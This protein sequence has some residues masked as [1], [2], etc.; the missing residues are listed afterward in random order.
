MTAYRD[1]PTPFTNRL[2]DLLAGRGLVEVLTHGLIAPVDHARLG[3]AAD[4]PA[5]IR[6]ANPVTADHS[7]MRRSML[8]GLLGVVAR[9]ERQRN[10]DLQIFEIG[11]LHEWR[12]GGPAQSEVL[13]VLVSSFDEVKGLVGVVM[14]RMGHVDRLEYAATQPRDGVEHPGRTAAVNAVNGDERV[15]L[16]RVF[17]IDPRLLAAFEVKAERVAFALIQLEPLRVLA[18]RVPQVRRIDTL[19]AIE[20]DLAVLVKH[21]V[22]A[23][24]VEK[25]IRDSAGANLAKLTLFD[26]YTGAPLAADEVSLAY[27]LRYQPTDTQMTEQQID[28]SVASV[29]SAV[30]REVGGRIRSAG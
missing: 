8:P 26:R 12:D 6:V 17:E 10:D 14:A 18:E 28:E 23:A 11:N 30:A 5:T 13:A 4:D 9:N 3:L 25:A 19:P 29:T 22:A 24:D 1:E 15:P 16:G 2:R 20:R 27:R 7:E 21:D